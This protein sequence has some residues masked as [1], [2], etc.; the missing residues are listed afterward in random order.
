[1]FGL[2]VRPSWSPAACFSLAMLPF[3]SF[4]WLRPWAPPLFACPPRSANVVALHAAYAHPDAAPPTTSPTS[5]PASSTTPA[6]NT[7]AVA[8]YAINAV[9]NDFAH[10]C[11]DVIAVAYTAYTDCGAD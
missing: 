5:S 11:S 9:A 6:A 2:I 1:M 7:S 4:I 10:A 3:A 8:N